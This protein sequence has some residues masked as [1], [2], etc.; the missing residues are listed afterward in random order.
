MDIGILYVCV[1]MRERVCVCAC[2]T[3]T[4]DRMQLLCYEYIGNILYW[5]LGKQN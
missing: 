3:T 5:D 2:T 1:C 4:E